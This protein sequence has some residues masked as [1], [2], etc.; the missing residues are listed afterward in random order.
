MSL[1][2]TEKAMTA[3]D[4]TWFYPSSPP[5]DR[6][7]FSTFGAIWGDF[8]TKLHRE[9]GERG[10]IHWRQFKKNPV[11]TAPR[12]CSFLYLVAVECA[13]ISTKRIHW[14][15]FQ[16][17]AAVLCS[18]HL[19]EKEDFP[20]NYAW[21]SQVLTEIYLRRFFVEFIFVSE[22]KFF[23]WEVSNWNYHVSSFPHQQMFGKKTSPSLLP[24]KSN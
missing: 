12:N 3:R 5:G 16:I 11:E 9:P 8:L 2:G 23:I 4:V 19:P 6:G 13:L 24:W 7:I 1:L 10:K 20:R 14:E 15:L 21:N 22:A 17:F 18:L